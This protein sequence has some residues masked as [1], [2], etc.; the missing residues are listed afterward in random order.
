[1]R[2]IVVVAIALA[3]SLGLLTMALAGVTQLLALDAP[4]APGTQAMLSI[5][6][7]LTTVFVILALVFWRKRQPGEDD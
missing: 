2:R 3:I 6:S 7:S 4:F 5:V 1:M